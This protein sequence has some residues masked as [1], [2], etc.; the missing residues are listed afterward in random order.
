MYILNN[1]KIV[2][3]GAGNMAEA[4][5]K[6][7]L[8]TN[9]STHQIIVTDFLQERLDHFK[10]TYSVEGLRDNSQAVKEADIT[11]LA[12]K[13][14]MMKEVLAGMRGE[15]GKETSF[16]SI[17]AGVTTRAIEGMLGEGTSVVRVMPNTP[18]LVQAGLSAICSGQWAQEAHLKLAERVFRS[19]GIVV[20]VEEK[21]MDAVA[22]VSGSGPAYVF[23]LMEAMEEAACQL[24]L[25]KETAKQLVQTTVQGAAQLVIQSD[26]PPDELRKRVTSKGGTTEAA[27]D[28]LEKGQVFK[29]FIDAIQAAQRRSLELSGNK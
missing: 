4:L 10:S 15:Y 5:V 9:V 21:E 13:P 17:A 16:I 27:L 20:R 7:L 6:G 3:I 29:A 24:G 1:A 8:E 18:A 22:A 28:V 11:V 25:S 14:Q 19:V 23:Y 26:D 12:V 2:F